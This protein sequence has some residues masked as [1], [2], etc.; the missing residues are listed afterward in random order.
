MRP[1]QYRYMLWQ[2]IAACDS[3]KYDTLSL[4]EVQQHADAGTIA[5]FMVEKFGQDCDFSLIEPSDWLAI[6]ETWSSIANAVEPSRKFGVE[7]RGVC[8]LMAYVL[9]SLQM[10]DLESSNRQSF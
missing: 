1:S 6:S 9:E 8:L 10:L 4:D 7:K 2:L 3:G 5:S